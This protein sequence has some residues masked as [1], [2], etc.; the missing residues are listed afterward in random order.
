M[1]ITLDY[2][3]ILRVLIKADASA[4]TQ[5]YQ[6][7]LQ[8]ISRQ[9][10]SEAAIS[11]RN[12]LLEKAY[13]VLSN[14]R[15]RGEYDHSFFAPA[16]LEPT[17]ETETEVEAEQAENTEQVAVATAPLEPYLEI[18][19]QLLPGV[20]IILCEIAEYDQ[21]I[22]LGKDYLAGQN[23]Q[24]TKT[25]TP[26]NLQEN[27]TADILLCMALSYLE[28]SREHWHKQQWE[29]AA[30]SGQMGLS[31]LRNDQVDLFPTLQAEILHELNLLKPYRVLDLLQNYARGSTSRNKGL[32]LLESMLAQRR[33][34][35]ETVKDPSGLE[36][37]QFLQFIQQ[38]RTYL[39]LSEQKE[40]FLTEAKR[41]SDTS[42]YV[43]AYALVAEGYANKQPTAIVQ[44][45]ALFKQIGHNQN[46][47]WEQAV[48]A[49]LLGRPEE[50][51]AIVQQSQDRVILQAIEQH[52][53]DEPD[54]LPG[55]CVHSEN[56]LQNEVLPQFKDLK[57]QKMTLRKYFGDPKVQAYLDQITPPK[58]I[59]TQTSAK[60]RVSA[61]QPTQKKRQGLEIGLGGLIQSW[62][63]KKQ[64]TLPTTVDKR[65]L[66]NKSTAKQQVLATTSTSSKKQQSD[67]GL[68]NRNSANHSSANRATTNRGSHRATTQTSV[69]VKSSPVKSSPSKTALALSGGNGHPASPN[70]PARKK[71]SQR[72]VRKRIPPKV[73]FRSFLLLLGLMLGLGTVGFVL[74]KASL[75]K[76]SNSETSIDSGLEPITTPNGTLLEEDATVAEQDSPQV[77]EPVIPSTELT[78]QL[79]KKVVQTWLD[80]KVAALGKQHNSQKLDDV[81]TGELLTNWQNR[82]NFYKQSNIYRQFEH[83]LAIRSVQID[84]NNSDLATVQAE[85]K[86]VAKHYQSGQL[87]NQQSYDETLVVN[88]NLVLQGDVW[89][90]Q[91]SKVV[92][93]L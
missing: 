91:A 26:E 1:R 70:Q 8:Q 27:G 21:V 93:S 13:K 23:N 52:S 33:D 12:K 17:A 68:A 51:Q 87:N 30:I 78:P 81:L 53:G 37:D 28:I 92:Q 6:D 73:I 18:E 34:L 82:A 20:L 40:I 9:E 41:G 66:A 39:T 49:L 76:N 83:Q 47:H 35:S 42:N 69:A 89:K 43:A 4:I 50:S 7:R 29:D 44:A 59:P 56:W 88:Y 54:L 36:L 46:T 5:A 38:I 85:V 16:P 79:A 75:D 11:A 67:Y 60:A 71:P 22:S 24:T 57:N 62:F 80:S 25:K 63:Q 72:K 64:V 58:S 19:P 2:Y 48:C 15:S 55:I 74:T 14:P 32:K 45:Q 31:L 3:R 86:E 10:Y 90:I 65:S 77:I 61:S 84:P